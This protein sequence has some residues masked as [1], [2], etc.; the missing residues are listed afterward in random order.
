MPVK[1]NILYTDASMLGLGAVLSQV[2]DGESRI[3]A[4]ASRSIRGAEERYSVIEREALAVFWAIHHFKFYLWGL[5][6]VVRTDH[7][8]LCQVFTCREIDNLSPRIKCWIE[9]LSEFNFV[10]EYVPGSKNIVA[11]CLSRL[12]LAQSKIVVEDSQVAWVY[13]CSLF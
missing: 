1:K 7:R 3:I 2:A 11:D 5:P 10:T 12:P 8:P 6:I 9:G 13:E 4:F